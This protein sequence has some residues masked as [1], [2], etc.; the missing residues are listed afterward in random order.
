[1]STD[2]QGLCQ[3]QTKYICYTRVSTEEQ[4]KSGAG[5]QAQEKEGLD[6]A[7]ARGGSIIAS[8][9][10]VE[11][12]ANDERPKL[13]EA[14]TLCELTGA[15]LLVAKI[16][17]L[18]RSESFFHQIKDTGVLLACPQMPD[19]ASASGA[20]VWS[21]M[22]SVAALELQM[23]RDR[24]KVAL[25]AKKAAGV[26]LGT[27]NVQ[28]AKTI[29]EKYTKKQQDEWL[30]TAR[31]VSAANRREKSESY[32]VKVL[33][34]VAPLRGKGMSLASIADELTEM[35]IVSPGGKTQWS[36]SAVHRVLQGAD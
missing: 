9:S 21:M 11:S 14:L 20:M 29:A 6:Y 12:G 10:E 22:M 8:F 3:Q 15:V 1:M 32:R 24:T 34:I 33:P 18:T 7:N 26:K 25:A 2:T 30:D 17:R 19:L 4:G 23:I 35:G 13:K 36:K 27:H 31:G 5:L 28:R 16:D